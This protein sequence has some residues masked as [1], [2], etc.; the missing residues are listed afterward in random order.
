MELPKFGMPQNPDPYAIPAPGTDKKKLF[1]MFGGVLVLLLLLGFMLFGGGGNAGQAPLRTSIQSTSDAIGIL[2]EY[3]DD[4]G[5]TGLKND[6][7]L[8]LILLRGNQQSMNELYKETYPKAKSFSSSPKPDE[9]STN[10]L[11]QAERNNVLDSEIITVLKEKVA[12]AQR[13]LIRAKAHFPGRQS[14]QTITGTQEDLVQVMDILD[15]DR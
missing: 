3:L 14:R 13:S 7:S 9:A 6:L 10:T 11:D 12:T 8:A 1:L 5:S 4:I 2:D 15:Q